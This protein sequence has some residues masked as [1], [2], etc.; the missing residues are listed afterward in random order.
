M[1][2]SSEAVALEDLT[3]VEGE[4]AA[5]GRPAAAAAAAARVVSVDAMQDAMEDAMEGAMEDASYLWPGQ[6]YWRYVDAWVLGERAGETSISRVNLHDSVA[7]RRSKGELNRSI[8]QQDNS[9]YLDVELA[10]S[11]KRTDERRWGQVWWAV[12]RG[13]TGRVMWFGEEALWALLLC[14]LSFTGD[15]PDSDL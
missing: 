5:T 12:G 3:V 14:S 15:A 1:G 10:A 2:V 4:E 8:E 7:L 6:T 11:G 13:C 9:G